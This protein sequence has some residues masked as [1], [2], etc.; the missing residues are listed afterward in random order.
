MRHRLS[1]NR[2]SSM[3]LS[4]SDAAILVAVGI[5]IVIAGMI[6]VMVQH[7]RLR[8]KDAWM[9]SYPWDSSWPPLSVANTPGSLTVDVVRAYYAF[10][11]KNAEVLGYIP[12][13]CGCV[14]QGHRSNLECYVKQRSADGHVTEWD[15]HAQ[16]CHVGLDITGDVTV[17]RE[18]GKSVSAIRNDIEEEYSS[19]GAGTQTPPPPSQ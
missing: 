10:A 2:R 17:W 3:A 4:T 11:G 13:Y 9:S 14:S 19:R 12:C 18:G 6:V 5:G 15:T 16:T 1:R 8:A 7:E